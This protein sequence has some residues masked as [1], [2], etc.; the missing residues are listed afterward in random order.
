MKKTLFR[1]FKGILIFLLIVL[2]I[3]GGILAYNMWLNQTFVTTCYTVTSDKLDADMRIVELSDLHLH[4]YG[5]KNI[6]LVTRIR[7]LKP[8]LI[9]VAG[10]MN[11]DE[12]PDYSVVLELMEQLLSVL[13]EE[14]PFGYWYFYREQVVSACEKQRLYCK[15]LNYERKFSHEA[16]EKGN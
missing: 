1:I 10:D 5:E 7:N 12:N 3:A 9:M 2:A 15:A 14:T 11:I 16:E 13:K 8:D 4:E 6:D